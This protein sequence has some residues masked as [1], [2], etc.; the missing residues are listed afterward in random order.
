MTKIN[1]NQIQRNIITSYFDDGIWDLFIGLIFLSFGFFIQIDLAALIGAAAAVLITTAPLLKRSITLPR[2]GHI[3][4]LQ[5]TKRQFSA[6]MLALVVAGLFFLILFATVFA[7][8]SLS[9][10]L[11]ENGLLLLGVFWGLFLIG[12]GYW[13]HFARLY[14]YAV[15]IALPFISADWLLPFPLKI[16]IAGGLISLIGLW[17]M[18]RF[19]RRYPKLDIPEA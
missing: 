10:L 2:Y 17:V 5:K 12:V 7:E 13:L 6:L 8:S 3:Q 1:L 15:L 16:M 9:N 19:M 11:H 14:F 18:I 4:L